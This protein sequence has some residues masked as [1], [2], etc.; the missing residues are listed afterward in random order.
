MTNKYLS[1]FQSNWED[2]LLEVIHNEKRKLDGGGIRVGEKERCIK[3]EKLKA[4]NTFE[5]T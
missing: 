2:V 5:T 3:P 1:N 4:W